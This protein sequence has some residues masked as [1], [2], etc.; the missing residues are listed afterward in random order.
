M[1]SNIFGFAQGRDGERQ[2][3]WLTVPGCGR[4][5]RDDPIIIVE[6]QN[7]Q[8]TLLVYADIKASVPTHEIPLNGAKLELKPVKEED[9]GR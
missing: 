7:G 1:Q 6:I 5:E 8:I 3:A 4:L 9:N 2:S